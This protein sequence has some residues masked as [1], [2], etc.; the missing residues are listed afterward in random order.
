MT[1][2]RA[3]LRYGIS[4]VMI[5]L[6][7]WVIYHE[8][9]LYGQTIGLALGALLIVWAFVRVWALRRFVERQHRR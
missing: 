1:G 2:T 6:G 5:T 9:F 7:V 8:Y 4:L 3:V